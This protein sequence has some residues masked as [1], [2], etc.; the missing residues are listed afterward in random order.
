M[1]AE[2]RDRLDGLQSLGKV[3]MAVKQKK[4][5][6]VV[7]AVDNETGEMEVHACETSMMDS[8]R[9][10]AHAN[11]LIAADV[12]EVLEKIRGQRK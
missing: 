11:Y 4:M 2:F 8:L 9:M 1:D 6:A 12:A 5:R 3:Y 10:V 7:I